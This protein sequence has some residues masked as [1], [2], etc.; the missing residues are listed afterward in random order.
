[1]WDGSDGDG[2]YDGDAHGATDDDDDDVDDDG[3]DE[4]DDDDDDESEDDV[5]GCFSNF[6][7][8]QRGR[9]M[10]DNTVIT[11]NEKCK[12]AQNTSN[13][14]TKKDNTDK[15]ICPFNVIAQPS[16]L[17]FVVLYSTCFAH[18]CIFAQGNNCIGANFAVA[19]RAG[20]VF[21]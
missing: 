13:A 21:F 11:L 16:T 10:G 1:M 18:V 14:T 6:A 12:H 19:L 2:S 5:D 7:R 3:D 9:N 20:I 8:A 15:K 17:S 4:D